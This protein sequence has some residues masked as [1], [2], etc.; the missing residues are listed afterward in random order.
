MSDLSRPGRLP[1][2]HI[3]KDVNIFVT[4]SPSKSLAE[5]PQI[6]VSVKSTIHYNHRKYSCVW[7]NV[8]TGKQ[9]KN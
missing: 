4:D 8:L 6:I 5:L 7:M 3:E 9:I 2:V 1:E